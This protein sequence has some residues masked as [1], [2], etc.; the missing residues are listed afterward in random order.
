MSGRPW[1]IAVTVEGVNLPRFLR[2][3]GEMGLLLTGVRI[4]GKHLSAF[5]REDDVTPLRMMA[6][7]GGWRFSVGNR[8]GTG[9]LMTWIRHRLALLSALIFDEID[10]GVSGKAAQKIGMKL[11]EVSRFRQVLCVTHLSQIAVMADQHLM[12]EKQLIENRTE[13]QV[14]PLEEEGRIY[15]IARIMGGENPSALL[16][17]TAKEELERWQNQKAGNTAT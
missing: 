16:L 2:R 7:N 1:L 14:V 17:Q 6:E 5:A 12:I 10:T 3:A 4:R 8:Q 15:E 9:R 13:T 11:Q